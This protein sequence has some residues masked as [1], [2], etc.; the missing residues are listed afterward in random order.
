MVAL[1]RQSLF[2]R[3]MYS[4]MTAAFALIAAAMA[5]A[6]GPWSAAPPERAE[7]HADDEPG[8]QEEEEQAEQDPEDS[9]AARPAADDDH[10]SRGG[11]RGGTLVQTGLVGKRRDPGAESKDEDST[12]ESETS[13]HLLVLRV[14]WTGVEVPAGRWASRWAGDVCQMCAGHAGGVGFAARR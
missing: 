7:R 9:E 6:A 10:G 3:R 14:A 1:I 5:A 8:E 11:G 2:L 13:A 12:E 4:T